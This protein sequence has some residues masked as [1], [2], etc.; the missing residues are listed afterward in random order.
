MKTKERIDA[1]RLATLEAFIGL[2]AGLGLV[3]LLF[4]LA[5]WLLAGLAALKDWLLLV[6]FPALMFAL[7]ALALATCIR[8]WLESM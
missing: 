4:L 7:N 1:D 6:I 8:W 5:R 3:G 2:F